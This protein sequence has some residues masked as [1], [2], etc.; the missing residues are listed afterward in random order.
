MKI[1][2]KNYP[3]NTLEN[4]TLIECIQRAW[5]TLGEFNQYP[6]YGFSNR[7][8]INPLDL[9]VVMPTPFQSDLDVFIGYVVQ[10][11]KNTGAFGS[12]KILF[13]TSNGN[14]MT[15]ENQSFLI[16]PPSEVLLIKDIFQ[17]LID[18]EKEY[19]EEDG[20]YTIA[21]NDPK[22]GFIIS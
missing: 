5:D 11:R 12:D 2:L 4:K 6:V 10:I 1:N 17:E 20:T 18:D 19:I 13:R 21:G 16:L 8:N 3:A 14:L 22:K 9:V 7:D 15:W